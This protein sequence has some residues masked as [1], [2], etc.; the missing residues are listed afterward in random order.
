MATDVAAR[1]LD[2]DDLSHVLNYTL[3]DDLEVYIH[4]SGRTG[5]AGKQGV[6]VTLVTPKEEYRIRQIEKMSGVEVHKSP[7]P[8][9]ED[10]IASQLNNA[11]TSLQQATL[12]DGQFEEQVAQLSEVMQ[13]MEPKDLASKVLS[14]LSGSLLSQYQKEIDLNARA[15]AVI[16]RKK[17]KK[18][19]R[20]GKGKDRGR[21]RRDNKRK[22]FTRQRIT[23]SVR[24]IW[25]D[26]TCCTPIG[27]WVWSMNSS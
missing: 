16:D 9:T 25:V 15:Q 26:R 18:R 11:I 22:K 3:P 12:P 6:A 5:R 20:D 14:L 1:G 2:V 21:D 7:I 8:T 19:D 27:C 4:R 10:V 17:R 24:S 23:H 13:S